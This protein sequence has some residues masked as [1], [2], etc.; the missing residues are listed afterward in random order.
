M[1]DRRVD[2][3]AEAKRIAAR[4]LAMPPQP[5]EAI[6]KL[7]VSPKPSQKRTTGKGRLRTGKDRKA[8]R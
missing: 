6:G 5:H 3:L 2:E 4:M 8:G 7:K 1:G